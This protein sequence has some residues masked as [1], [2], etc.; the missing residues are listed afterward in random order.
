[1]LKKSEMVPKTRIVIM[2]A[3]VFEQDCS[4]CRSCTV[5]NIICHY[6]LRILQRRSGLKHAFNSDLRFINLEF[7]YVPSIQLLYTT[8]ITQTSTSLEVS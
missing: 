6:H 5:L 1:M 3:S 7:S 4:Q 2:I 8:V